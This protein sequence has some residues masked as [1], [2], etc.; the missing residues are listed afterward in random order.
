MQEPG[1]WQTVQICKK[2]LKVAC[3]ISPVIVITFFSIQT[4]RIWERD[5]TKQQKSWEILQTLEIGIEN[6]SSSAEHF[7]IST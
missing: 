2:I 3:E 5:R 1:T 4:R 7:Q 6:I